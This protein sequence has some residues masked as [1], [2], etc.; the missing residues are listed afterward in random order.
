M[1]SIVSGCTTVKLHSGEAGGKCLWQWI[2]R[3]QKYVEIEDGSDN[4][5]NRSGDSDQVD[6]NIVGGEGCG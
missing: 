5:I 4:Y 3:L 2:W 1:R 6:N